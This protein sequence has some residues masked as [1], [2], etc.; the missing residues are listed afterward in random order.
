MKPIIIVNLLTILFIS[1]C[2]KKP[3][4]T[5]SK[6]HEDQVVSFDYSGNWKITENYL[7]PD[8]ENAHKITIE[9]P[10]SNTILMIKHYSFPFKIKLIDFVNTFSKSRN[11]S[12][13]KSYQISRSEKINIITN[14]REVVETKILNKT[15][16]GIKEE[17]DVQ[18]SNGITS[19]FCSYY[20]IEDSA[21]TLIIIAQSRSEDWEIE[22]PGFQLVYESLKIKK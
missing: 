13:Q 18:L 17:F 10:N 7:D 6:H 1:A 15:V 21:W 5:S 2:V 11:E 12:I 4:I 19:L 3:D 22:K 16:S 8:V 9:S 20:M 14:K